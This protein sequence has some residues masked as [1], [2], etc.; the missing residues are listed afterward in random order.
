MNFKIGLVL[1]VVIMWVSLLLIVYLTLDNK[2][3]RDKACYEY[4]DLHNINNESIGN[5]EDIH[6]RKD[7][8]I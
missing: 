8:D 3:T 2:E 1:C 7:N 5:F 4:C 6:M